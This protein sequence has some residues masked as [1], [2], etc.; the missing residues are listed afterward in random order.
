MILLYIDVTIAIQIALDRF[1]A[2]I[3]ADIFGNVGAKRP[4]RIADR[5]RLGA[6][7]VRMDRYSL[8]GCRIGC[9]VTVFINCFNTL[10]AI[11]GDRLADAIDDGSVFRQVAGRHRPASIGIRDTH[12]TLIIPAATGGIALDRFGQAVCADRRD[13]PG[14]QNSSCRNATQK[15]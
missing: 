2:A 8:R 9:T 7:V 10:Q 4:I 1:G 3:G 15:I 13:R 12:L 11:N 5:Y 14:L 6:A